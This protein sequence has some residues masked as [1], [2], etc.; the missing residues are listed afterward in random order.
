MPGVRAGF[1]GVT[2]QWAR[3]ELAVCFGQG[4]QGA[5]V[6]TSPGPAPP[7]ARSPPLA[8]LSRLIIPQE[9]LFE[10]QMARLPLLA[11]VC[12]PRCPLLGFLLDLA[13]EPTPVTRRA[14][15]GQAPTWGPPEPGAR[16]GS[17]ITRARKQGA[18]GNRRDRRTALARPL[19]SLT[20]PQLGD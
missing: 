13:T 2:A 6:Q 11:T 1:T 5:A 10:V 14:D 15:T 16:Q 20:A 9:T 8:H 19:E 17:G 18:Q 12:N 3:Q 7:D 4:C